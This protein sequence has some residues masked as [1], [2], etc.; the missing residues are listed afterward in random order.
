MQEVIF[1][2]YESLPYILGGCLVTLACVS[3]ALLIGLTL[4]V[5]LAVGQVYGAAPLRFFIS[6]YVWFF[7][8]CPLLVQLY[9]FFYGIFWPLFELSALASSCIVLGLTSAAYQS[10]IFRGAIEAIPQG[11]LKAAR[12][13]GLRDS[14]G[15]G[16]IVLP[17]AMRL[18]IPGWS[19]EFSILLKDSA[20]IYLLGASDTMARIHQM[21][22]TTNMHFAFSLLAG[23]IYFVI[24]LVGLKLLR[25]LEQKIHIPGY[26]KA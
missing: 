15:I 25:G 22:T 19:N 18:A 24:T 11:Q 21:A 23:V 26:Q 20:L 13:L 14:N 2:I 7:R 5:P 6:T 1:T 17:Q 8:G 9:I 3:V 16:F 12:A 4:G 10:Q